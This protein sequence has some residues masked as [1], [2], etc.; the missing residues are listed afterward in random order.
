M[1]KTLIVFGTRPELIKLIPIFIELKKQGLEKQYLSIFTGQHVELTQGLF[2]EFDF[3]PDLRIPLSNERNSIGLSFSAM[4]TALQEIVYAV[5]ENTKIKMIVAQ[6]DTTTC[7]CAAFCAFINE[8]PFAHVEAGLRTHT[9]KSPFPEEYFRR[10]IS[11]SSSIHFAPTEGAVKNLLQEGVKSEHIY[12][13]GNTVVDTIEL[14]KRKHR[15]TTEGIRNT[16]LITCHRRENQ[17]GNFHDLV[18]TIKLLAETHPSLNFIWIAHKTPFV[19]NELAT[20]DFDSYPSI[21]ISPPLPLSEMYRL[22]SIS[23]L[24]ITDSGGIQEEACSFSLPVIV[25]RD[26]TERLESL[27]LG[28]SILAQNASDDLI[29]KFNQVLNSNEQVMLNPY[30]DGKSAER[31]VNFLQSNF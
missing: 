13:S 7:A 21:F 23:K 4:L 1:N 24:I 10:I 28:Y 19:R 18:K 11:L 30:G 26:T 17:N 27:E 20:N 6:G 29:V 3:K 8:I 2:E 12:L 31:I 15:N 25:I 9:I 22:Y 16:I 14:M 5:Q